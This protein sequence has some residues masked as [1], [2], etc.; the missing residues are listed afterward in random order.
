MRSNFNNIKEKLL[1]LRVYISQTAL[2]AEETK[3]KKKNQ[4]LSSRYHSA[5]YG[6]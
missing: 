6:N 1:P 5:N 4:I 2:T 3:I